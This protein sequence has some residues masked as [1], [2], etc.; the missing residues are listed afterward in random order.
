MK[1]I[2]KINKTKNQFFEKIKRQA[3]SHII[4]KKE[5]IINKIR[6]ENGEI[7]TDL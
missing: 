6:N 7:A 3:V 2:A 4:K 1:A 5:I